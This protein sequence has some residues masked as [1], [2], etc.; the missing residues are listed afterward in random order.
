MQHKLRLLGY[1]TVQVDHLSIGAEPPTIELS[2]DVD[3][4]R[5]VLQQ[6]V[7]ELLHTRMAALL[8]LV[9]WNVLMHQHSAGQ[10]Q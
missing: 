1:P 9:Q 3:N 2:D 7:D 8:A 5:K 10:A 4:L 6:L